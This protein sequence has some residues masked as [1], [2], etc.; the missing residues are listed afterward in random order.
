MSNVCTVSGINA[1]TVFLVSNLYLTVKSLTPLSVQF[2]KSNQKYIHHLIQLH[3]IESVGRIKRSASPSLFS[4]VMLRSCAR[5]IPL[6]SFT[7]C[8]IRS[9]PCRL[10]RASAVE[11]FLRATERT[12][13]RASRIYSYGD[14]AIGDSYD[15]RLNCETNLYCPIEMRVALLG[16][17]RAR[18][19][20]RHT[21]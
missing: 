18:H 5:E 21:V 8:I 4:V 15:R 20:R 7:P 9:L 11:V 1:L 12:P 17:L 13:S 3:Y 10:S 6:I 14:V 19:R 16:F 2:S